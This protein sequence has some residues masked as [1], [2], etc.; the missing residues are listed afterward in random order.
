[1]SP[2]TI[3]DCNLAA[4]VVGRLS[5]SRRPEDF[6]SIVSAVTGASPSALQASAMAAQLAAGGGAA[7]LLEI[8]AALP[9]VRLHFPNPIF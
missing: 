5:C 7:R 1:M 6:T 4:I 9:K 3:A 8:L 2:I